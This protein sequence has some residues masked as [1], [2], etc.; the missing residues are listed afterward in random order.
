MQVLGYCCKMTSFSATY[1]VVE[2]DEM[3]APLLQLQGLRELRIP[4][5]SGISER[6]LRG[7]TLPNLKVLDISH[8]SIGVGSATMQ[9]IAKLPSVSI[10]LLCGC[11]GVCDEGVN[12]LATGPIASS[13][14]CIGLQ[15]CPVSNTS[16]ERLLE[17]ATNLRQIYL[18]EPGCNL[19]ATGNYTHSGIQQLEVQ[20]PAVSF[21]FTV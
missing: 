14:E 12:E 7:C 18:A 11:D 15:Y 21:V 4:G 2:G 13:L 9:D 5:I 19:W 16:L 1:L 6:F 8:V 10:L 3:L 20:F 17:C